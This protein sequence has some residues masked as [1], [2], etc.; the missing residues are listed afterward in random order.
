MN[1]ELRLSG[2]GPYYRLGVWDV[3]VLKKNYGMYSKRRA[4]DIAL[5]LYI[6][7]LHLLLQRNLYS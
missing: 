6:V 7:T 5:T 2:G 3:G 4:V 1:M